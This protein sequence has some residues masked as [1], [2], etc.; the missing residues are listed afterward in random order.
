MTV[1]E[2]DFSGKRVLVVEDDEHTRGLVCDLC[3]A[4]Q[5][6]TVSAANGD[7]AVTSIEAGT[8]DLVLLDLMLPGRDGFSV[9]KW[10]RDSEKYRDVPVI[11]LSAVADLDGKIKGMELGADDYMTKPFKLVELQTR[12]NSALTVREFRNRLQAAE[13]ELTQFR[14]T[15]STTGCGTYSHLRATLNSEISRSRRYGRPTAVVMFGMT[16]PEGLRYKLGKDG[17]DAF[18]KRLL[19]H[20]RSQLR[21]ADTDFR[22]D[23]E[24]FVVILP[25][26][27]LSGARVSAFRL[28]KA[29]DEVCKE[30]HFAS[31]C[32][33]GGAAFPSE[34]IR[35]AEDL[36]REV[37]TNFKKLTVA[38]E[39]MF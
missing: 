16:E 9:L 23:S 28:A 27:D 32:R 30:F 20:M 5:F 38:N 34:G 22:V 4:A 35:S 17:S 11:I 19:Q 31:V 29:F 25:E 26:T 13:D 8:P 2:L 14:A 3:E 39:T 15:D 7:D 12:I 24:Q 36:L 18:L 6:T 37:N 33:F 1:L 10:M 21:G